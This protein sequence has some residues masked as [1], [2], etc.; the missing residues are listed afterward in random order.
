MEL[1][2]VRLLENWINGGKILD[3]GCGPGQFL[4]ALDQRR[5]LPEGVLGQTI[6][7]DLHQEYGEMVTSGE[8]GSPNMW[9][10]RT[11]LSSMIQ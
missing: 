3:V 9:Y 5:W 11:A 1:D 8:R 7:G 4:L 6:L 10:W 2:K